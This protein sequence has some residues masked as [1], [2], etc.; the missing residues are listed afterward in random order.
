ME[1]VLRNP[2]IMAF[3]KIGIILYGSQLAPRLPDNITK[4]FHYTIVKILG[5]VLIAYLANVDFQLSILLAVVYILGSNY[6][7]GRKLFESFENG[8]YSSDMTKYTD[9][10][11]KPSLITNMKLIDSPSDNFP[12]CQDVKMNDLLK[13]FE[14]DKIKLQTSLT[15]AIKDLTKTLPAGKV[16]ENLMTIA[17]ACGL[18]YNVDFSDENAPLIATILMNYGIVVTDKCRQPY[19]DTNNFFY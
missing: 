8:E 18:P 11:G 4:Y 15:Y 16:R 3:L 7:S 12:G 1:K 2:Y 14:N 19:N 6:V 13:L 9:L 5:V 17:K 10:L